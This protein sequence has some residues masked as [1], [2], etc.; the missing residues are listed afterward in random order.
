MERF[1][2]TGSKMFSST[3]AFRDTGEQRH[4]SPAEHKENPL[5]DDEYD[6]FYYF[7][8]V[9]KRVQNNFYPYYKRQKWRRR[10]D[11]KTGTSV[12]T[13]TKTGDTHENLPSYIQRLAARNKASRFR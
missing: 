1:A 3:D 7:D 9:M 2:G 11:E 6:H 8:G 10:S 4:T 12:F 5:H 13:D